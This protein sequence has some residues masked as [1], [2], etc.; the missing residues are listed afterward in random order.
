[1]AAYMLQGG[2]TTE[3]Q[4]HSMGQE[5]PSR[6]AGFRAWMQAAGQ[7]DPVDIPPESVR[8]RTSRGYLRDPE[9]DALGLAYCR[10]CHWLVGDTILHFCEAAQ[11]TLCHRVPLGVF[12]GYVLEHG[13]GRLVWEG[14]LDYDRILRS[15]AVDFLMS[16]G[17]YADR[18][19]GGASGFMVCMDSVRL[20]GKGFY[21]EVDHRT[22]TSRGTTL[23]GRRI[24]GAE[25]GFA[26]EDATVAGLKREF[27]MALCKGIS[28]WWFDMFGNWFMGERVMG[29]IERMRRIGE[30]YG[31]EAGVS[32]SEIAVLVDARSLVYLDGDAPVVDD[33]Y[34][35]QRAG[36]G[37]VGAPCDVFSM[38]DLELVDWTRYRLVLI[39]A[40]YEMDDEREALL[41]T[42]LMNG[43]RTL[44]WVDAP[45]IMRNGRYD[46]DAVERLTGLPYGPEGMRERDMGNWRSVFCARPNIDRETLVRL[47]DAAGVHRYTDT[48]EPVYACSR[49]L[50]LHTLSGGE[51]ALRLP[52][53]HARVTELFSGRIVAENADR[54]TDRF[55]APDTRF[56]RLEPSLPADVDVVEHHGTTALEPPHQQ[57][58]LGGAR[59]QAQVEGS[60]RGDLGD[61]H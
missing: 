9:K 35:R 44:V 15:E 6:R 4:D 2:C 1:M 59:V 36:L 32:V 31:A 57:R 51:R 19:V 21:H 33:L 5:S 7:P 54:F 47:A 16:P 53:V 18:Q 34:S 11:E 25:A 39:P 48:P 13:R 58:V 55:A 20:H 56:Y 52:A 27:A 50:A 42:R 12:Y 43:G 49:L 28:L 61:R 40:L 23:L 3:W 60:G 24:P 17:T 8:F 22:H 30:D 38:A 10:Y 14:H 41:R 26:D 45:G 37:R 46:P 29:A